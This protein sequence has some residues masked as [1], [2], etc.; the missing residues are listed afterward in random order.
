[1]NSQ[2]QVPWS[3][4]EHGDLAQWEDALRV[5][6]TGPYVWTQAFLPQLKASGHGSVV[7]IGSVDGIFGNPHIPGY[8]V[9]KGGLVPLT[10]VMSYELAGYGIRVNLIGRVATTGGRSRIE[11]HADVDA[12]LQRLVDVTPLGR[13]GSPEETAA[14]VAF[15][16]SQEASYITGATLIVDG[17]RTAVTHGTI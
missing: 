8:S 11:G 2:N 12:Y 16:S 9:S 14:A 4:I 1:V 17:G 13:L 6:L 7:N 5:N 3:S 10:H 15:L